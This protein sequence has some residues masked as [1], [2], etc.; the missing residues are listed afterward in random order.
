METKISFA[1]N[2]DLE[3]KK[4]LHSRVNAY[5]ESKGLSKNCNA[6]MVVKTIV[7]LSL[8]IVPFILILSI[9]MPYWTVLLMYFLMGVGVA[10]IGMSVMHDANHFGYSK[11]PRIN[12]LVGFSMNLLGADSYNWKIKHNKLH[13]VFTN[14]Y[15]K[16]EDINSRVI[17]RFAFGSPLKKYHRYQYLYAWFFYALMTLSMM[18]GDISKRISN[19]KRGLT[20]ISAGAF[21]RSMAWLI[22]SK[23]LYFGVIIGLPII[24][25]DLLWWQVL[26]GFLL[27]HLVAGTIMS[28]IFQ[29]AHVVE[30]TAQAIPD[31][32]GRIQDSL[33]VHQLRSTADFSKGNKLISWYVGGLN[34]QVE[35]H[36]YPKVCHV[37]YPAIARIVETTTREFSIPYNVYNTFGEAIRAHIQTLRRLGREEHPFPA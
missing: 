25:T 3:F 10:G 22:V 35:H 1:R 30:G 31:A 12:R 20:N 26:L 2:R 16:D 14:I 7:M 6:A 5:F 28:L 15:G 29:M 9:P 18:F 4:A 8:Y 24:L 13:H 21:W 27:M 23:V 17:L 32:E 33:I 37:H 19:R 11:N 36:L 34:F